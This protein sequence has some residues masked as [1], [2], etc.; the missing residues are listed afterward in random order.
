MSEGYDSKVPLNLKKTQE[1]FAGVITQ[2]MDEYDQIW[3]IA[4]SGDLIEQE[5]CQFITPG[6]RLQPAQRIQMYNQ[7]YW[8]RLF[9]TMHENFLLLVRLFGYADFNKT[10]AEPYFV[11]YPSD[12]WSIN[13]LGDRLTQWIEEDYH[14]QDKPLVY[15]SAQVD[16]AY[17]ESFSAAQYPAISQEALSQEGLLEQKLLLQPHIHLFEMKYNIFPFRMEFIKQEPEYWL[18]HDFPILNRD[19][20]YHFILYRTLKNHIAYDEITLGEYHLLQQFKKGSS[21]DE[22][23]RWLETQDNE[24]LY[25][26]ASQNLHLWMQK[27]IFNQWL[28]QENDKR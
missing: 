8:W 28:Y 18:E 25:E 16:W 24:S 12:H 1:W 21:I 19:K 9:N 10:I 3:P 6:P 2:P 7:Q 22:V 17:I 5:A 4:P 26:E 15:H 13:L 14:A 23:C 20:T 27:W 11:K